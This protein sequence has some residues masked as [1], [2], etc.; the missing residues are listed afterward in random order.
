M[1]KLIIQIPCFNEESTLAETLAALPRSLPGIDV[2]ETLVIDDGSTDATSEVAKQAGATYLLRFPVNSGLARAFSAGL[3]TALKLGADIIVNTDADHQYPGSEIGR[4]VEPIIAGRVEMMIG[5]RMP[6]RSRHFGVGKRLLQ[7]IGSWVVRQLSGTTVPDATS[8]FR[9]FSRRAALRLNVF[10]KFTYTLETIIQAGKKHIPIGHFPIDTNP[11]KRP[12]RLFDSMAS[13]IRRSM[14]TMVRIYALYEP[15]TVFARLGGAFLLV[16]SAIG[17]RFVYYYVT[18]GGD[19]HIQ[20]LILAAV[21]M[22]TG[23]QTMLIGLV[24]DLIGSSRSLLEDTLF[25]VREIELR[26]GAEPDVQRLGPDTTDASP[27]PTRAGRG[28]R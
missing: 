22:I 23:F 16:G 11:E 5:D 3:D 4:L 7:G 8:G 27:E 14:G 24:A 9:A 2:I 17:M 18:E 19:G 28:A 1:R 20:S 25:R 6:T 13:Y 26:L 15:L 21:L 10:T 12:S